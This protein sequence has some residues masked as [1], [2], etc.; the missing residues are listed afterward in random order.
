MRRRMRTHIGVAV[1]EYE[2]TYIAVVEEENDDTYI[3]AFGPH[4]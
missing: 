1:E 4:T 2:D 3:V